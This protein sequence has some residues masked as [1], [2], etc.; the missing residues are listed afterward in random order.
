MSS[1]SFCRLVMNLMTINIFSCLF[2]FP[3]MALDMQMSTNGND[4]IMNIT[5][6]FN[7]SISGREISSTSTISVCIVSSF[8]SSLVAHGSVLAM[9]SVGE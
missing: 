8:M 5:S 6:G 9:L 3:A 7:Q 1:L 4:V 2:L